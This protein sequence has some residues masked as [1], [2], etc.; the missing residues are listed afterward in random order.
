MIVA[1]DIDAIAGRPGEHTRTPRTV[2]KH[3][4]G[5]VGV[6]EQLAAERTVDTIIEIVPGSPGTQCLADYAEHAGHRR[7]DQHPARLSDHLQVLGGGRQRGTNW[8]TKA[9]DIQ[10][11][12]TIIGREA[13]ADVQQP[14]PGPTDV[15]ARR[16]QVAHHG[17]GLPYGRDMGVR[18]RAL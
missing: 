5:I 16:A 1:D 15:G 11:S 6:F 12:G 9:V 10:C 4:D 18:P 14:N 2:T 13:T 7:R 3:P 8:R 17:Q